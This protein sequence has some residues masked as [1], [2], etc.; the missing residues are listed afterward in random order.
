M[1]CRRQGRQIDEMT[2]R[3]HQKVYYAVDRVFRPLY[4]AYDRNTRPAGAYPIPRKYF[5]LSVQ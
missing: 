5:D 1:Y 3:L 2:A 4:N